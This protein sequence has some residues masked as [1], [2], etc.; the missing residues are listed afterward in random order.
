MMRLVESNG[1]GLETQDDVHLGFKSLGLWVKIVTFGVR[2]VILKEFL[3][4]HF[5]K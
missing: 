2:K 1:P 3:E 4:L 5:E